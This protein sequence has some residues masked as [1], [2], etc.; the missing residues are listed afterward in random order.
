[1]FSRSEDETDTQTAEPILS[2][3]SA[4]IVWGNN[5]GGLD[6]YSNPFFFISFFSSL[7]VMFA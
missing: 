3:V 2:D 4:D 6:C 5:V 1:M 7:S